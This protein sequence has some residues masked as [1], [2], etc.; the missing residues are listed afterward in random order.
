MELSGEGSVLGAI[1][2]QG[3]VYMFGRMLPLWAVVMIEGK[4]CKT[5]R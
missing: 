3:E 5:K 4:T 2:A 1:K